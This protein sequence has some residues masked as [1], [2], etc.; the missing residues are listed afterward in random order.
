MAEGRR[1]KAAD[2]R[3]D[4]ATQWRGQEQAQAQA[5]AEAYT[6]S[7]AGQNTGPIPGILCTQP[8]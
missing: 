1:Q 2:K 3:N 4:K 8:K 5:Q 7:Q 6:H